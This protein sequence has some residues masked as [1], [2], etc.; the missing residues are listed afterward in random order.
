MDRL[1]NWLGKFFV[2]RA[3][4]PWPDFK[5]QTIRHGDRLT[6]PDGN[7]FTAIRLHGHDNEGD[8]WRA[9]YDDATVSRLGLQIADKG[10]AVVA[11]QQDECEA[12]PLTRFVTYL[13]EH[14]IGQTITEESLT[15]WMLDVLDSTPREEPKNPP[16]SKGLFA[17]SAHAGSVAGDTL[18]WAAGIVQLY[19]DATMAADYMVDANDVEGILKALGDYADRFAHLES[20]AP[21]MAVPLDDYHVDR[22]SVVW[23]AWDAERKAWLGEPAWIG[24][25]D[26]S[27]WPGYHTHFIP[28]PEFPA[29]L[30]RE[31]TAR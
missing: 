2:L 26:D 16:K 28:H 20:G 8:A 21:V 29:A 9:V 27:D 11:A 10:Q 7:E 24:Q 6:H 30:S 3:A 13:N 22:G 1:Q 18:R 4:A 25:P 15:E 17:S 14:C 5:G 31:Q 23:F 19:D 12:K